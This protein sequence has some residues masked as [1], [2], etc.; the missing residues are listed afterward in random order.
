MSI[1]ESREYDLPMTC[2]RLDAVVHGDVGRAQVGVV[3]VLVEA[4]AKALCRV[5]MSQALEMGEHVDP[6]PVVRHAAR[7]LPKQGRC[8]GGIG[9]NLVDSTGTRN[10]L[11]A[12]ESQNY[13]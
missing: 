5:C 10:I 13:K 8:V 9:G 2:H 12:M 11:K 3:V 1:D 4:G 6:G 7:G